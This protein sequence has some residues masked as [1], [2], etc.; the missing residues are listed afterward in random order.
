MSFINLTNLSL[1]PDIDIARAFTAS[2]PLGRIAPYNKSL[3]VKV[4]PT[5][6]P[7]VATSHAI[8]FIILLVIV[9]LEL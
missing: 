5:L 8:S 2:A 7:A 3:Y 9:T 6:K 4:S 1:S